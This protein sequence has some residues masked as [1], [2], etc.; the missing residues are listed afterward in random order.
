[1]SPVCSP[2][3]ACASPVKL[4]APV[5]KLLQPLPY[6][7]KWPESRMRSPQLGQVP[8]ESVQDLRNGIETLRVKERARGHITEWSS[9]EKGRNN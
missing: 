4:L 6:T 9:K 7:A 1:M 8:Q 3:L 2:S 5:P